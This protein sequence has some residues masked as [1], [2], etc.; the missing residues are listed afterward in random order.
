MCERKWR[1]CA[2]PGAARGSV[3]LDAQGIVRC[4]ENGDLVSRDWPGKTAMLPKITYLKTDAAEAEILTGTT[5]RERAARALHDL[6]A[7]EVMVTH[8]SEVIV[9]DG[10]RVHRAPFTSKNLSG[11]TGRGDTCFASYL[12]WRLEHAID[13]SVAYAAA[14]TSIKMESPGPFAS[15]TEAVFARMDEDR[16]E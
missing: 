8:S 16:R 9:Y 5:D 2:T 10:K 14:L 11:R 12:A 6:G 7:S 13:E 4:S 15:S 3:A 1:F